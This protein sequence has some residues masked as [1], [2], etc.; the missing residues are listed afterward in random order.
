MLSITLIYSPQA[1]CVYEEHL[2]LPE[3]ACLEDALQACGFLKVLNWPQPLGQGLQW[4]IWGR[5]LEKVANTEPA[6]HPLQDGDRLELYRPLQ[7]DPKTARRLRFAKQGSR[8]AGLFQKKPKT[9]L[10]E[11]F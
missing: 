11:G 6:Q 7:V 4:G 10:P 5:S 1:R 8:N 9:V 2:Q 3:G